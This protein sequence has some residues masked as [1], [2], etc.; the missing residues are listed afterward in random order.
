MSIHFDSAS[1]GRETKEV[2]IKKFNSDGG[3]NDSDPPIPPV[4]SPFRA[5]HDVTPA[6]EDMPLTLQTYSFETSISAA[7][8]VTKKTESC[9]VLKKAG[10]VVKAILEIP[11]Y[12][13]EVKVAK[14]SSLC[15][16]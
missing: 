8:K 7:V 15:D 10:V 5:L 14:G 2:W 9:E 4:M 13:N 6:E 12:T 3:N 1:S 16:Q 11:V